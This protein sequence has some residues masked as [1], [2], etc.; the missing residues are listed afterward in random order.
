MFTRC[1]GM[2]R[3][4]VVGM[5]QSLA[6]RTL[7]SPAD[8]IHPSVFLPAVSQGVSHRELVGGRRF[9]REHQSKH[10]SS[11]L[12][13]DDEGVSV[14]DRLV[15]QRPERDVRWVGGSEEALGH[16]DGDHLLPGV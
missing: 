3:P 1:S 13:E 6:I 16:E 12:R 5:D 4:V 9:R 8:A 7:S 2:S 10:L 15:G 14:V 11:A